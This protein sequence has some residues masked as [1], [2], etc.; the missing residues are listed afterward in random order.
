MLMKKLFLLSLFVGFSLSIYGQETIPL[1]DALALTECKVSEYALSIDYIPLETTDDCLIGD[2]FS[3]IVASQDIFVHHFLEKKIY[4]FDKTGKFLNPIG[5]RGQGPGEYNDVFGIYADDVSQEC[6]ILEPYSNRINVYDYNGMFKRTI[7]VK[8]APNRMIKFDD[9]YILNHILMSYNKYEL[10]MINPQGKIVKQNNREGNQRI[11]FSLFFPFFYTSGGNI[12]YKN[13]ISEY[14]YSIDKDLKRKKVYWLDLGS[15]AINSEENQ[16]DLKKGS[17]TKDKVVVSTP[18]AYRDKLFIP[19]A[20]DKGRFFAVY[21]TTSKKLFT[22][23]LNGKSGFIDDLTNGPLV[24]VPY[25]MYLITSFKESQL[26]SV[27][28]MTD[29]TDESFPDGKFKQVLDKYQLNE[30]SNPIIRIVN[31]K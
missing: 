11:G 10:T 9:N 19:Y 27:I 15:K 16:Y 31:L 22:P 30:D 4:R 6:F 1:K 29:I 17:L 14:I 2:E 24:E 20:Y 5:K 25:S 7:N 18:S 12:Y 26:V 28:N 3:L 23:G 13:H 21:N 8:S